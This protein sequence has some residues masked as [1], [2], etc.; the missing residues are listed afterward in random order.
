ML[1]IFNIVLCAAAVLFY[2]RYAFLKN[3]KN[4]DNVLLQKLERYLLDLV[5]EYAKSDDIH[6]ALENSMLSYSKDLRTEVQR[7]NDASRSESFSDEAA[8]YIKTAKNSYFALLFSLCSTIKAYGD[9]QI[10]G[11]SLFAINL[12]YIKEEI[13]EALIREKESHFAFIGLLE[14][15]VLPFI[16]TPFIEKWALSIDDG[17]RR[18]YT[19]ATGFLSLLACFAM[20]IFCIAV[21]YELQYPTMPGAKK[22]AFL[23]RLLR[24]TAISSA[25]DSYVNKN[26]ARCLKKNKELKKLGEYMNIK[27]F[28]LKRILF[29]AMGAALV[30]AIGF[31]YI[32][33]VGPKGAVFLLPLA[34]IAGVG[35]F[36]MP[37]LTLK[38]LYGRAVVKKMEE[39]ILFETFIMI[40][41]QYGRITVEEILHWMEHF[42]VIF[43]EPLEKA[44]DEYP[45]DRTAALEGLKE[46]LSFE[47]ADR[48]TD[49]LISCDEISISKAFY[50]LDGERE[51]D[52]NQ[53]KTVLETQAKEKAALA[54]FLAFMPFAAVLALRLIIPFVM[55]GFT[56]M[57]VY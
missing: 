50:D 46:E 55:V 32:I 28:L 30:L 47:P 57:S 34:V 26:Y 13:R 56:K 31:V 12:R 8:Y 37:E 43:K 54:K 19:G 10:N 40:V 52:L 9:R 7:L 15:S 38:V 3:N 24:E 20:S 22:N 48:L 1:L 6:K 42:S 51:Y 33:I 27:E 23:K 45:E 18:F 11:V 5:N 53:Y 25:L 16:V 41:K 49:A 17:M 35:G 39:V 4:K 21:I 2:V 36:M 14:L 29:A 44:L